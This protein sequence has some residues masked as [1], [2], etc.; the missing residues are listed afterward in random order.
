MINKKDWGFG[1]VMDAVRRIGEEGS[2]PDIAVV[3]AVYLI[4]RMSKTKRAY[5]ATQ[6]TEWP[7]SIRDFPEDFLK[8]S[9][10]I[11][12]MRSEGKGDKL[13]AL[14]VT[15]AER[16]ETLMFPSTYL[17]KVERAILRL[18]EAGPLTDKA[19]PL[20]TAARRLKTLARGAGRPAFDNELVGIATRILPTAT[21]RR[22]M[23][24]VAG[25]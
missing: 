20:H 18:A 11:K 19:T 9:K 6:I 5:V 23:K 22:L 12:R 25:G 16:L 4:S 7:E 21:V 1:E 14:E 2:T 8:F 3:P 13:T 15:A 24:L 17:Q 10:Y